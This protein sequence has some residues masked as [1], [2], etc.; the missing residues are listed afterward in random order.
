MQPKEGDYAIQLPITFDYKGGRGE[1]N[2]KNNIIIGIV[3]AIL[4]IGTIVFFIAAEMEIWQKIVFGLVAAYI[5]IFIA[6]IVGF[7]ELYYSDIYE[8]LLER[9]FEL[10]TEDMWR[11]FNIDSTYPYICYYKNGQKGIF[12]S[13]ERDAITGKPDTAVYDHYNA[14]SE[15]Y[16]LA[17]TV[18]IN[19]IHIDY[20]DTVGNDVRLQK[21]KQDAGQIRNPKMKD[22]VQS[23]YAHLETEMGNNYASHDIYL[24]LTREDKQ[25]FVYNV[26]NV[27]ATM[28]GGNFITYS[29]MNRDD[30]NTMVKGLWNIHDFS[31]LKA[32]HKLIE[33]EL[34]DG[35]KAISVSHG[36]GTVEKINKT[37]EEEE[38][39]FETR[40]R[41]EQDAYEEKRNRRRKNR[42]KAKAQK[43]NDRNGY[44]PYTE[45]D[46]NNGF[47]NNFGNTYENNNY[48]ES[49]SDTNIDD[50]DLF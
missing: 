21:M 29:I 39:E 25:N 47:G 34:V 41:K 37:M 12:V 1:N 36:D 8:T 11:I 24:F 38:L 14:I 19:I 26:Q 33:S 3:F 35:I 7:N 45:S 48:E 10:Y 44:E 22:A 18:N 23:I 40:L 42:Q 9:D 20:M 6:R 16:N 17:H 13:M 50:L 5:W 43:Q 32:C 46:Y 28:L 4:I 27:V 15:A 30:I 2:K 49:G 31:I